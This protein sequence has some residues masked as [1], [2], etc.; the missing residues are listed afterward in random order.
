MTFLEVWRLTANRLASESLGPNAESLVVLWGQDGPRISM[1]TNGFLAAQLAPDSAWEA[2]IHLNSSK[3]IQ[4]YIKD[5]RERSCGR[6]I[7][8]VSR[9]GMGDSFR[10]ASLIVSF[11]LRDVESMIANFA[12][13]ESLSTWHFFSLLW[14]TVVKYCTSFCI[15][16]VDCQHSMLSATSKLSLISPCHWLNF[17]P[18]CPGASQYG[19][20]TPPFCDIL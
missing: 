10:F 4:R 18:H 14:S 20:G 19:N 1:F 12:F 16:I 13:R 17:D 5:G 8:S 3:Y 7:L 6:G 9:G 11:M 15:T 2:L